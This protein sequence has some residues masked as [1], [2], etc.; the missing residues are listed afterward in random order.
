MTNLLEYNDS[1]VKTTLNCLKCFPKLC[2]CKDIYESHFA[3]G[4]GFEH[5]HKCDK[6]ADLSDLPIETGK[7]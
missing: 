1:N 6:T 4:S 7:E 3:E 5:L 2:T